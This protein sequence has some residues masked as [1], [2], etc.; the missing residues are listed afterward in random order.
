MTERRGRNPGPGRPRGS[1][2]T[3]T[4]TPAFRAAAKERAKKS[5][6]GRRKD[7]TASRSDRTMQ[8]PEAQ[9]RAQAYDLI[10]GLCLTSVQLIVARVQA[11]RLMVAAIEK[12]GAEMEPAEL[13]LISR[14]LMTPGDMVRIM[15]S[16]H[17][18]AGMPRRSQ[19]EVALD[20]A[21]PVLV[22][23]GDEF[24]EWE[25]SEDAHA[26]A[27]VVAGNGHANGHSQH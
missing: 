9:A 7:D 2:G 22:V 17:D 10:R 16:V 12:R 19:L 3:L 25:K 4:V 14:A 18:R 6:P 26:A 23:A 11:D 21:K 5:R 8:G 20:K 1:K 27:R 24:A 13:A 15:D